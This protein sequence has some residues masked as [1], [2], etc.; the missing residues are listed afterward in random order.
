MSAAVAVSATHRF[1]SPPSAIK[2]GCGLRKPFVAGAV[3]EDGFGIGRHVGVVDAARAV[4][5]E[6]VA[7]QAGH[8]AA[9]PERAVEPFGALDQEPVADE[10]ARGIVDMLEIVDVDDHQHHDVVALLGAAAF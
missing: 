10:M 3:L 6:L 2:P 7:A 1:P 5:D 8:Q 4:D 9:R